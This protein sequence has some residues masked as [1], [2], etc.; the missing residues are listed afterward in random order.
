[1]LSQEQR[2]AFFAEVLSGIERPPNEFP[3]AMP[4]RKR[5][6]EQ[7]AIAPP[8]PPRVLSPLEIKTLEDA[9]QKLIE[10]LKWRLGPVLNELKK[11]YKKFTRS[12]WVRRGITLLL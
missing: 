9:D 8:P 6:L 5:V 11:R 2:A 12:V 1:M 10:L 4:R 3:D 7:L